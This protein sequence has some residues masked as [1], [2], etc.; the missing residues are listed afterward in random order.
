MEGNESPRYDSRGEERT[1]IYD[2]GGVAVAE[3]DAAWANDVVVL[4]MA[5]CKHNT[6]NLA[7][8][9]IDQKIPGDFVE[10]GVGGG[11]HP[12]CMAYAIRKYGGERRV[13]LF[14]SFMGLPQAGPDDDPFDQ[15]TLGVNSDRSR[16]IPSGRLVATL[17]QV[18]NNV[19]KW[20]PGFERYVYHQG[21][22]Q[23]TAPVDARSIGQIA[24]LRIDVDLHDS[25]LPIMEH[26]YPLVVPGGY[27]ISDDWGC[28]TGPTPARLA[29]L[30]YI[31]EPPVV[32][33]PD[34]KS[35]VWW[36]KEA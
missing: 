21:W 32:R 16:G 24:L 18:H 27:I 12:A 33:L 3:A 10:C 36:R 7:K 15:K 19:M 5:S 34:I 2:E 23:E 29:V 1:V 31:K 9:I 17:E 35:T 4:G 28:E 8:R 11:G 13:H 20:V 14:D 30:K 6:I 25:T 26:L 22:I